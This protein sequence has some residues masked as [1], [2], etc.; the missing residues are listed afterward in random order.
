MPVPPTWPKTTLL[1][2]TF[3]R[4]PCSFLHISPRPPPSYTW[5]WCMLQRIE[6]HRI[7]ALHGFVNCPGAERFLIRL[8][9]EW[10]KIIFIR[11]ILPVI[12][13][14]PL[15]PPFPLPLPLDRPSAEHDATRACSH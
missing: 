8:H 12:P 14:P 10:E 5:G 4:Q 7:R 6:R 13:P 1:P 3:L 2:P 9:I 15:P 11:S